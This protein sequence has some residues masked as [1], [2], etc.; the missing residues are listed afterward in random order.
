MA[1][2][3]LEVNKTHWKDEDITHS[4]DLR[5]EL[6]LGIRGDE[7]GIEAAFYDRQNLSST[8]VSVGW[9]E[10]PWGVVKPSE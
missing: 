8:R 2:I 6:V 9:D 7:A 10:S 5:D 4:E 3:L 1:H